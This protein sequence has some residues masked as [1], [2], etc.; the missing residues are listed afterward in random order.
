M[1][2]SMAPVWIRTL[3]VSLSLVAAAS[4]GRSSAAPSPSLNL[5]GTWTGVIGQGAGADN[6]LHVTWAATQNGNMLSGPAAVSTSPTITDTS[7]FGIMT[8][9]V[10]GS[11]VS[12]ALT[13]QSPAAVE[14][15]VSGT[16]TAD[17]GAGAITGDLTVT[18]R[19][20]GNLQPPAN[21][22]L[23]LTKQ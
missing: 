8:G 14:C 19:S 12:L 1:E 5:T 9:T 21:G 2:Q 17:A 23:T 20:C 18:Y 13:A 3:V 22:H 7:F 16:G 11:Q 4:C 15:F 6:A 10:A